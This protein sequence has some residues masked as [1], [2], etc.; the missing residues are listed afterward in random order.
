MTTRNQIRRVVAGTSVGVMA[1][2]F[3]MVFGTGLAGAVPTTAS[4]SVLV[5]TSGIGQWID[6]E[7][8]VSSDTV[9]PGETVTVSTK[10]ST[11][12]TGSGLT[13]VL[14]SVENW[15]PACMSFVPG[16]GQAVASNTI[17]G[18]GMQAANPISSPAGTSVIKADPGSDWGL[19]DGGQARSVTLTT[20]YI[21]NCAPGAVNTGGLNADVTPGNGLPIK[22]WLDERSTGAGVANPP[23]GLKTSGPTITVA[24]PQTAPGA[25]TVA[26]VSP[27]TVTDGGTVTV[28]GTAAADTDTIT[29]TVGGTPVTCDPATV[30]PDGTFNC[31]F[32]ATGNGG[33]VEVAGVNEA[34]TSTT[35]TNAGTLTV[36]PA[37]PNLP[38]VTV[39]PV[40]PTAGSTVTIAIESPTGAENDPVAVT[41]NGV[42]IC[43]DLKLDAN[44]KATCSW[45]PA[46][47]GQANLKVVVGTGVDAKT[48]EKVV[49]VQPDSTGG[50]S[51]GSAGSSGSVGLI[52]G[53]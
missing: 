53:S 27:A 12:K 10:I 35:T 24:A 6:T 36:N 43:T 51:S 39:T 7:R 52:F 5:T 49:T 19:G 30:A 45:Q 37:N 14:R 47:A 13:A 48:V 21:V 44:K 3:A 9:A 26:V 4:G 42:A 32:T 31:T 29:V 18:P 1:A 17:G 34:G 46:D 25:P 2:S 28:S 33:A 40:S 22:Y 23:S 15:A 38:T 11:H 8:T 50:S 20:Q 41:V 16:S